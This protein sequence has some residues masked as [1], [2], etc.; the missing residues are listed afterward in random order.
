MAIP[1]ALRVS[2]PFL[3]SLTTLR[4]R[5][6][7]CLMEDCDLVISTLARLPSPSTLRELEIEINHSRSNVQLN[8][9][10]HMLVDLD[11]LV[12]SA[13]FPHMELFTLETSHI[14]NFTDAKL[15]SEL[16][17]RASQRK[18]LRWRTAPSQDRDE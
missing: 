1:A 16:L 9:H 3:S 5:G 14:G 13:Q 12:T 8:I 7:A 6:I 17:P 2:L 15:I 4:F 11:T 10:S 18:L